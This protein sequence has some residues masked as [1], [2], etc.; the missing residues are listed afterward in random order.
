MES[1]H[2]TYYLLQTG[3]AAS[4]FSGLAIKIAVQASFVPKIPNQVSGT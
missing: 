3:I 1:K 4:D 2:I